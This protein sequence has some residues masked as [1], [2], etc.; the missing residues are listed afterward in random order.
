VIVAALAAAALALTSAVAAPRAGAVGFVDKQVI[1]GGLLIQNAI[2]KYGTAHQFVYPPKAMV[3]KGGGLPETGTIWPSNPWTGK[4]MGPG[5]SRGTYTYTLGA[6]GT[7]YRLTMHLSS[8]SYV[9]K[10]SLP[11]WLKT[12][13]TAAAAD[14]R[15]A[16]DQTAELGGRLLKGFVDQW[17]LLNNGSAPATAAVAADGDLASFSGHWPYNPFT[18][19]PMAASSAQGDYSYAQGTGGAYSLAVRRSSGSA[20]DLSGTVPQQV[21][22]ALE[23]LKSALTNANIW[24]I[25]SAVDRFAHDHAGSLPEQATPQALDAYLDPWP[26]NPFVAGELMADGSTSAGNYVYTRSL[27][28]T[29]TITAYVSGG[30]VGETVSGPLLY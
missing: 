26:G 17:G 7:S 4:V 15:A 21:R 18:G 24:K 9:F 14:L 5:A 6:G 29:Y 19:Q 20:V 12:E 11:A 25:Q 22:T 8:G 16:R 23:S 2:G 1:A 3:R 10:G 13:R 30:A 28:G 27:A